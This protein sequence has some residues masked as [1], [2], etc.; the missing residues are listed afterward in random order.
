MILLK[1]F[2]RKKKTKIYINIFSIIITILF[3]LSSI[4]LYVNNELNEMKKETTYLIMFAKSPHEEIFSKEKEI[5]S[6][7][8]ALSLTKGKDNNII[9][10]PE[11]IEN[12]NGSISYT[13]KIDYKKL[14]W[15]R[16]EYDS[17]EYPYILALNAKSCNQKLKENEIILSLEENID[18]RNEYK[19][20]YINNE[21]NLN[22]KN[23][24]YNLKI[25]NIIEP[26]KLKYVCIS[27]NLYNNLLP[28]E[29]NYIYII[30]LLNYDKYSEIERK[31]QQLEDNDFYS[32]SVSK[33]YNDLNIFNKTNTLD[34][35]TKMLKIST[36]ISIIIFIIITIIVI[37]D[38]ILEE[39]KD[40][41]LLKQMGYNKVQ[42]ILYSIR[43]LVTLDLIIL[44]TSLLFQSI[45]KII[46]NYKFN[47]KL[48]IFNIPLIIFIFLFY[49]ITETMFLII[50][51]MQTKKQLL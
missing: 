38:L 16:L 50:H 32:I 2:F 17:K 43:N 24:E 9:Y 19:K 51:Q 22:H 31:W 33:Y 11:F 3:L 45:V 10:T 15:H 28:K 47:F 49:I 26:Q 6:Y 21:I 13:E 40:I 35:L 39:E 12:P 37:K 44:A 48:K 30:N 1:S 27:D 20:N 18:Y 23:V 25:K 42:I 41:N 29:E 34:K 46:I 14:D 36:M 8:R 5:A 4:K 7:K